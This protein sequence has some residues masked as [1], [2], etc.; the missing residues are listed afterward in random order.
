MY[1]FSIHREFAKNRNSTKTICQFTFH[2]LNAKELYANNWLTWLALFFV[3]FIDRICCISHIIHICYSWNLIKG[4]PSIKQTIFII[5]YITRDIHILL[6]NSSAIAKK[7][8]TLF[9]PW[10][11]FAYSIQHHIDQTS[12][13]Y[14]ARKM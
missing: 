13:E 11:V 6:L 3:S 4:I 5:L 12:E 2:P 9:M 8:K 1:F 10:P 7:D 14:R